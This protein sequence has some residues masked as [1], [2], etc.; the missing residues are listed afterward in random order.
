[1]NPIRSIFGGGGFQLPGPF[2]NLQQLI[3]RFMAFARNPIG[4]IMGMS[5]VNVPQN[6]NG[7]A[8]DLVNHLRS[9]G[10]M[11]NEQFNN[12]SQAADQLQNILP[13]F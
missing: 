11:S 2:G 13:K 5:N 12:F 8:Q 3:Q 4:A 1:M 6:F 7:S 9:T 10:Q